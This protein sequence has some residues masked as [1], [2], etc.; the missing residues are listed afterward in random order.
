M[1]THLP[2]LLRCALLSALIQT[3]PASYG[4]WLWSGGSAT[5]SDTSSAEWSDTGGG[6]PAGQ[7]VSFG[8]ENDGVVTIDRVTP[9]SVSV[10]GGEYTLYPPQ[11][12]LLV[13]RAAGISPSAGM[14]PS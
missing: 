3:T 7:N 10:L 12:S 8:A 14:I 9:A 1:K 2:V 4:D 6:E 11:R 13:S 5:W